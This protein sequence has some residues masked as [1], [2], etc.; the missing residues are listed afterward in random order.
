MIDGIPCIILDNGIIYS[1]EKY[2]LNSQK[3]IIP[4]NFTE[5]QQSKE[6]SYYKNVLEELKKKFYKK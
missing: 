5:H 4:E 1:R 2:T 3:S 6:N